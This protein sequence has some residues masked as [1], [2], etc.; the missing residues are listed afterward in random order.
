MKYEQIQS[1]HEPLAPAVES[2]GSDGGLAAFDKNVVE[3]FHQGIANGHERRVLRRELIAMGIFIAGFPLT[4]ALTP[5][6]SGLRI[7][8]LFL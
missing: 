1:R 8:R 6:P 2:E 5:L 3:D 4:P 7:R